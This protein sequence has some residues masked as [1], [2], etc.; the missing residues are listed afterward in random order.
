MKYNTLED[1]I[2]SELFWVNPPAHPYFSPVNRNKP[3]FNVKGVMLYV[4]FN[5]TSDNYRDFKES[6]RVIR[7][8]IRNL[9]SKKRRCYDK[10]DNGYF[11]YV[12]DLTIKQKTLIVDLGFDH[13]LF[14][15][16]LSTIVKK[17]NLKPI[18]L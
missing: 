2:T 4:D 1:Q 12:D 6:I 15:V 16:K 10:Y 7:S 5:P 9:D 3:E 11:L 17:E 18:L 8:F 13:V 14:Y